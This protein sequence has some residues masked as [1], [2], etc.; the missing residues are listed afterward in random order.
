MAEVSI[1]EA[2]PQS[3]GDAKIDALIYYDVP[4]WTKEAPSDG[5]TVTYMFMT[6]PILDSHYGEAVKNFSVMNETQIA[7]VRQILG[8]AGSVTGLSFVEVTDPG[9][10]DVFFGTMDI[11]GADSA[12][13]TYS[14]VDYQYASKQVFSYLDRYDFVY[15]DNVEFVATNDSPSAGTFGYEFILHEVGHVLGLEDTAL[16]QML[17]ADLDTTN[18]TI[19]SY[20]EG[21]ESP[22]TTFQELDQATLS[23]LYGGSRAYAADDPAV[24]GGGRGLTEWGLVYADSGDEASLSLSLAG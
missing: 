17:S 15:L 4:F 7:S 10:T 23:Y 24:Y 14:Y 13:V 22:Q 8:Y 20:T 2:F 9:S 3:S 6:T 11:P 12:A 16:S 21:S 5:K 1:S 18:Y 19:M